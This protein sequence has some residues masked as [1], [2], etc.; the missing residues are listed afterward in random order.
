VCNGCLATLLALVLFSVHPALQNPAEF[1][2]QSNNLITGAQ[3]GEKH[4]WIWLRDPGASAWRKLIPGRCPQWQ[5]DG[6]R[7]YYFLDVGYDGSR[8]EL[9]SADADGEARLRLTQSDYF[10]TDGPVVVSPDGYSLAFVYHT[11]RASGDFQDVVV[12]DSRLNPPKPTAGRVVLRTRSSVDAHS[13]I[14]KEVGRLSVRVDGSVVSIDATAPGR[15][16][17]P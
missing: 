4:E 9:W 11:S 14:W 6:K 16:Q 8:A 13:L 1:R 3:L 12:I 15:P 7:F 17:Q 5:L 2:N 10:I